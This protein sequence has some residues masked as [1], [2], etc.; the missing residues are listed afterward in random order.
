MKG[1]LSEALSAALK[2]RLVDQPIIIVPEPYLAEVLRVELG[3]D[4]ILD[5]YTWAVESY[6]RRKPNPIDL[7][8]AYR[9]G[10]RAVGL[11]GSERF[12][13]SWEAAQRLGRDY[14]E[15]LQNT[16]SSAQARAFWEALPSHRSVAIAFALHGESKSL[17]WLTLLPFPYK[18]SRHTRRFWEKF[19]TFLEGY[20]EYLTQRRLMFSEMA[21]HK[22]LASSNRWDNVIFLHVY[23]LY[24]LIEAIIRAAPSRGAEVWGWDLSTLQASLPEVWN[25]SLPPLRCFPWEAQSRTVEISQHHTLLEVVEAAAERIAAYHTQHPTHTIAI[26]CEGE[27]IPLLRFF[28]EDRY[29]LK[30]KMSPIIPSLL[31]GTIV[32]QTLQ[33]YI[34]LGVAGR[35]SE[36]PSIKTFVNT[37]AENWAAKLYLFAR[38]HLCPKDEESWRLLLSIFQSEAPQ[39]GVFSKRFQVYFGRL[40]QLAGGRYDA[41][42]LIEPPS[43]PLGR[44]MRPSFWPPG[45]RRQFSSP[46]RHAQRGWRLLSLLLWGSQHLYLGR[47]SDPSY[48]SSI[49]ELFRH[50]SL[51]P[52][53]KPFMKPSENSL[54]PQPIQAPS[55]I[56]S[57]IEITPHSSLSPSA[58]GRL[59]ICPR[60]YFWDSLLKDRPF[61]TAALLG[62]LLHLSLT[63][64][65]IR[66]KAGFSLYRLVHSLSPRR[67]Y[68]RLACLRLGSPPSARLWQRS[69]KPIRPFLAEVGQ[70]FLHTLRD[71]VE[72]NP[73]LSRY[74]L[75]WKHFRKYT[76]LRLKVRVEE[77]ISHPSLPIAGRIDILIE[78]RD[79]NSQ[80]ESRIDRRALIDLKSS[81]YKSPP[82][83]A[84]VI[85]AAKEGVSQLGN[86]SYQ[87][88]V[89]YRDAILQIFLYS[90][91][92]LRRGQLRLQDDV[93]LLSAWWRPPR[94]AAPINHPPYEIYQAQES[95]NHPYESIIQKVLDFLA[96]ART[97]TDFP[98]TEEKY[99][100]RAC[101][102]SILCGRLS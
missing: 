85:E 64:A 61:S 60:R 97:S 47:R 30:E 39:T 4:S 35:L 25:D 79:R 31:E 17:E 52:K 66:Y 58:I 78:I 51:F 16:S 69:F 20:E 41:L 46:L 18:E 11:E 45:L 80:R 19:L 75:R 15:L 7:F 83:A 44:W 49:E 56:E 73:D 100:C 9:A 13:E 67:L 55:P 40:S 14:E 27:A 92:L 95:L 29:G 28:L 53:E 5:I 90:W 101:E 91:I 102:F 98:M 72:S 12:A 84:E 88:P 87:T 50:P 89:G 23:G 77:P 22:I 43:E 8:Y 70:P 82:P 3:Y 32:G 65:L 93:I 71:L 54:P 81:V 2:E 1:I 74:P 24:P 96:G 76:S 42:F 99:L 63:S 36:W 6:Q 68:Y 37:A 38:A 62:Q 26:W 59:L 86:P 48:R 21:L 33:K 34:P 94:R 57:D 10:L